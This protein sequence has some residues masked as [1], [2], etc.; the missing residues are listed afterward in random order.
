MIQAMHNASDVFIVAT[1]NFTCPET[2]K[3]TTTN[4]HDLTWCLGTGGR[5]GEF[6]LP[7]AGRFERTRPPPLSK[8]HVPK[9]TPCP[10]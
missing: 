4:L 3:V 1:T 6:D 8:V 7:E 10:S 9:V 2:R 5:W